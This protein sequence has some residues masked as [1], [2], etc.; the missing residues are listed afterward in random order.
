MSETKDP[1]AVLQRIVDKVL[2]DMFAITSSRNSSDV[3]GRANR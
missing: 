2:T 1:H 3:D